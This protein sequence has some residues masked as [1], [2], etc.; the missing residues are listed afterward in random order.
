M[1][2]SHEKGRRSTVPKFSSFKAKASDTVTVQQ[3]ATETATAASKH[4]VHHHIAQS[5]DPRTQCHHAADIDAKQ[6]GSSSRSSR[7]SQPPRHTAATTQR[8]LDGDG[9]ALYYRDKR[10]DPLIVRYGSNDRNRVPRYRRIG[11]GRVLGADGFMRIEVIG[12][13]EE[14]FIRNHYE[15]GA[16]LSSDKKGLR[17]KGLRLD[18]QP[19]RVRRKISEA[20]AGTEDYISFNASKKRKR[21]DGTE[22][23]SSGDDGPSYRSIHGKSKKHEHSDSDEEYDDSDAPDVPSG[24]LNDPTTA[25]SI[26][27]SRKV[28]EHP[29]DVE[30]WLELVDHQDSLLEHQSGARAPTSAEIKSFADIKLSLLEQALSH[31]SSSR[32]HERLSLKI[33]E[34]GL[35][36]WEFKV[37]SKKF[38]EMMQK[39]PDSFEFWKLYVSFLQT[40]LSACRFDEIKPAYTDKLQALGNKLSNISTVPEQTQC[41]ERMIYVFLRLTRFLADTGFAELATAAWQ[42]TLELNLSRPPTASQGGPGVPSSFA[43]YWESEVPRLGEDGW[44][45]WAAFAADV[46]SQEPPEPRLSKP[47]APPATRDGYRAWY[48][49]ERYRAQNAIIPA[50]TLDEGAEDDP[51]RVTMFSDL[52]DALLYF[53]LEVVQYIRA[54]LLEAFLIF[55]RLPPSQ[56]PSNFVNEIMEDPFLVHSTNG[57][58]YARLSSKDHINLSEDQQSKTPEFSH[59]IHHMSP[60]PEVLFPSTQWFRYLELASDQVS[61]DGYQWIATMFKHLT[62]VIGATELGP[63]ALALGSLIEPGNEKKSAKALLKQD[64]LNADLYIGYSILESKRGNKAVAQN[65]LSAALGLP[66]IPTHHRIRLGIQAAWI[67]LDD[68]DLTKAVLSLCRLAEDSSSSNQ[69]QI[70]NNSGSTPSQVLKTTQFLVTNRDYKTSSGDIA[71]AAPYAEGLVLLDYLTQRGDKEPCSQ[72]QGD[73]WPAILRVNQ[74][75]EEL[76][77][78]GHQQSPSH[79][80]FLQSSARLLYYH[81]SHG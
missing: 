73:I 71:Q 54:Q 14:F 61:T 25:R 43:E 3:H 22:E 53:P 20:D 75:S 12:S 6:P 7:A 27:L 41:C 46:D 15:S 65:I 24:S 57:A 1:S 67:E 79:E 13:R 31:D 44:R 80:E 11:A 32:H 77:S 23:E 42:A 38:A 19:V 52:Q 17:A 36:V 58:L 70:S 21:D 18:S 9:D 78:R 39:Y 50:R 45:G 26:E 55:C 35:K 56:K 4:A 69:T 8:K 48:S 29:D 37:A 49:L 76:V 10:G 64:P 62:R 47:Q 40:R 66:S 30:S 81:A 72:K 59:R 60:T 34:E 33:M 5:S 16:L 68:G 74:F 51:F 28:R 2:S 63:Y